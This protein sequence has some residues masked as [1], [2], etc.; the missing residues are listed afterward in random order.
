MI[1]YNSPIR[2][3]GFLFGCRYSSSTSLLLSTT[4]SITT[5]NSNNNN[6][7]TEHIKPTYNNKSDVHCNENTLQNSYRLMEELQQE[8]GNNI[9][10]SHTIGQG[11]N[12][13][14]LTD[15]HHGISIHTN[16]PC[17][18]Q[19]K[20]NGGLDTTIFLN[21]FKFR[22]IWKH[23]ICS[24]KKEKTM[25]D[26]TSILTQNYEDKILAFILN[27]KKIFTPHQLK[28]V[29]YE[30]YQKNKQYEIHLILKKYFNY[31]PRLLELCGDNR[32]NV[33]DFYLVL[34][35]FLAVEYNLENYHNFDLLFSLYIKNPNGVKAAFLQRALCTFVYLG[36]KIMVKE[37]YLQALNNSDQFQ[38]TQMTIENFVLKL[39]KLNDYL[40]IKYCLHQW[41]K[42]LTIK[43]WTKLHR[44]L[45][46][47]VNKGALSIQE[48]DESLLPEN[49]KSSMYYQLSFLLSNLKQEGNIN[50]NKNHNDSKTIEAINDVFKQL[51]SS[52]LRQIFLA[53][54]LR[55]YVSKNNRVL[56]QWVVAT[57][58]KRVLGKFKNIENTTHRR[59]M[60]ELHK[61]FA[62]NGDLDNLLNLYKTNKVLFTENALK[63][64]LLCYCNKYPFM[65]NVIKNEIKLVINSVKFAKKYSWGRTF[66]YKNLKNDDEEISFDILGSSVV[67]KTADLNDIPI[68][69]LNTRL[70]RLMRK[71][72]NSTSTDGA[73]DTTKDDTFNILY[74]RAKDLYQKLPTKFEILRL[75]KTIMDLK[76]QA[77]SNMDKF[78]I[79][80]NGRNG[81]S[82]NLRKSSELQK[83]ENYSSDILNQ[84]FN[85]NKD[86]LNFQNCVSLAVFSA[87]N[88]VNMNWESTERFLNISLK[89]LLIEE[90]EGN[91]FNNGKQWFIYYS[92]CLKCYCR[93]LKI[94]QFYETLKEWNNTSNVNTNIR[95]NYLTPSLLT[96]LK[97]FLKFF[98]QKKIDMLS[99]RQKSEYL[100]AIRREIEVLKD[101]Y[102][103]LKFNA[104][105]DMKRTV[106][107]IFEEWG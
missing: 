75:K 20:S 9:C 87:S 100:P 86:A 104:L 85:E 27:M 12:H 102:I 84:Y 4:Y 40:L 25:L 81:E 1:S 3:I 34:E 92:A 99:E 8:Y 5:S 59:F 56:I 30:F 88:Y 51:K 93:Y 43:F 83:L 105:D 55:I 63:Q 79:V 61:Y 2:G 16:K 101:R 94:E 90:Q 48:L 7:N 76:V 33:D 54:L 14:Y 6:N 58:S 31:L 97:R 49:Y 39:T 95:N 29:V 96:E 21:N 107:F 26:N 38:V 82:G 89:K 70:T 19:R 41:K 15:T 73:M 47:Y 91:N 42:P 10:C 57:Y 78:G 67:N 60:A 36:D 53:D 80:N 17:N 45:L 62:K 46:S 71:S 22:H 52:E 37:F 50:G 98:E 13:T 103:E 11:E 23:R 74:E 24:D 35:K 28:L 44:T 69:I 64:L 77:K 72:L 32:K 106:N 65:K 18:Q 66:I 68:P